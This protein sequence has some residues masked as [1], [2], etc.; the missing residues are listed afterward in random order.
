MYPGTDSLYLDPCSRIHSF[1]DIPL[2]GTKHTVHTFF[3]LSL[4]WLFKKIPEQYRVE[5][6]ADRI[7]FISLQDEKSRK[8]PSTL[9][10]QIPTNPPQGFS[11]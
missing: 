2:K 4:A 11:Q 5:Y 9:S 7:L 3:S 8:A 6:E 10:P 1:M